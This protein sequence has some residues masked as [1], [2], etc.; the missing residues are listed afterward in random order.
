[1]K[2]MEMN[3]GCMDMKDGFVAQIGPS[4]AEAQHG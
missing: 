1:M 4:A 2:G 3:K